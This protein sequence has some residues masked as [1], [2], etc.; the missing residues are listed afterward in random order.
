[1]VCG[2]GT[3][4]LPIQLLWLNVVTDGFQDLALS[5]EGPEPDIMHEKPRSTKESLF[6]KSM[7]IQCSVMGVVIGLMVFGAWMIFLGAGMDIVIARSLVMTLMVFLQNVHAINC[8]S[9]KVSIFKMNLLANWF[10]A[11][12]VIAFVGLQILFM[13]VESL[14]VLLELSPVPYGLLFI[15]LAVSLVMFV[16]G[17]IYKIFVRKQAKKNLV[18]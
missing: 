2:A 17:E 11:V 8:K 5:L 1:M 3:P 10:F 7:V 4:L 15:L 13:E 16:I 6:T 14:S 18:V 9:E 12:S